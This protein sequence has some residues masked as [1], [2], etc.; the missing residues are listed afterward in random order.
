MTPDGNTVL[1]QL[2]RHARAAIGLI[3]RPELGSD[4]GEQNHVLA[5]AQAWCA[6]FPGIKAAFADVEQRAGTLNRHIRLL[7]LNDLE[8]HFMVSL[9]KK[10][11]AFF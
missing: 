5:L 1:V 3:G 2:R 6:T 4:I 7:R 9:A 8:P 11:A 10:A